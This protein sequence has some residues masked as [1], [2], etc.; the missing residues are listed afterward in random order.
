M[1]EKT[2]KITPE[3][4]EAWVDAE[5]QMANFDGSDH[6]AF[7]VHNEFGK[8]IY[9]A[10]LEKARNYIYDA[11]NEDTAVLLESLKKLEVE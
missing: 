10:N 3:L 1:T 9:G 2:I 7:F 6:P 5:K 8:I 4:H 11:S